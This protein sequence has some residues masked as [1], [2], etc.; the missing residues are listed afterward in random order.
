VA[1][2]LDSFP[3]AHAQHYPWEEWLDGNVWQLDRGTDYTAKAN[4]IITNART[5]ARRR[6]GSVRTRLLRQNGDEAIVLQFKT[7]S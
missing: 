6:G 7:A 4:T 1:R 2:R 3:A 5:Q